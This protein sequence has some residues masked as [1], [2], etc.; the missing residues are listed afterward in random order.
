[1][2]VLVIGG[3]SLLGRY[4]YL[5]KPESVDLTLTWFTNYIEDA[6]HLD[7]CTK[8]QVYYVMER[9]KP[10][11]IIHCA[12]I[13]SVD[14]AEK[15][16]SET[17][18]INVEGVENVLR[19]EIPFVYISTNAV[20]KGDNPPYSEQSDCHPVNCYGSIKRQAELAVMQSRKWMIIRP[21][22]LYGYPYPKGRQNWLTTILSKLKNGQEVHLVDDTYWQPTNAED[23]AL[24]IWGLIGK[25]GEIF[26][27]ASDDRVTLFEFGLKVARVFGYD[28]SLVQPIAS[29][30]L[31]IAPRPKD[32][33]FDLS[34]IHSL[35]IQLRGVEEGLRGMK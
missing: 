15:N 17:R 19:T 33:A 1:M 7:V 6:F 22:L 32:T 10:D 16:Y 24:A 12:A 11:V 2:K 5:T 30:S 23:C 20:F 8:S 9:A 25:W 27:V 26:H 34:K 35:G 3:S 29:S 18:Y 28:L 21:F 4:L 31:N 14:Y 13:G